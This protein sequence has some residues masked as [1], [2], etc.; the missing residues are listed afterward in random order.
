MEV[1]GFS[2]E[3]GVR[4][5][6]AYLGSKGFT[7]QLRAPDLKLCDAKGVSVGAALDEISKT[8]FTLPRAAHRAGELLGY[9]E[10][11]IEQGPVLEAAK[12]AVGVVSAIAGQT[13][14]R[15]T[16]RGQAGHAGTTPRAASSPVKVPNGNSS[17]G[18]FPVAPCN[19]LR[20]PCGRF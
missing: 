8:K 1:L 13:R 3:E 18:P 17:T 11:H 5:G 6:S 20:A 16:F 9:L 15:L 14:G 12:L 19:Y 2:E 4:F 7:G 10:I